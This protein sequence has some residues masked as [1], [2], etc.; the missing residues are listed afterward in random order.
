MRSNLITLI[1]G[2]QFEEEKIYHMCCSFCIIYAIA[3]FT[4]CISPMTFGIF[5]SRISNEGWA[6]SQKVAK[7][8]VEE[9]GRRSHSFALIL[10]SS[11]LTLYLESLILDGEANHFP[12]AVGS[13]PPRVSRK[14]T[15]G[16]FVSLMPISRNSNEPSVVRPNLLRIDND[17]I[18]SAVSKK[19]ED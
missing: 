5:T 3:D 6:C 15:L 14:D 9:R 10:E 17:P 7:K 1:F 2:P 16:R 11:L 19:S 4:E 8:A 12:H 13:D 18:P